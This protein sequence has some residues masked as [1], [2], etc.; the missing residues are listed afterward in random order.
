MSI[1]YAEIDGVPARLLP[2]GE[3][4]PQITRQVQYT[5][6]ANPVD[7]AATAGK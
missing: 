4:Q 1:A 7:P 3:L 6:V 5:E 2:E